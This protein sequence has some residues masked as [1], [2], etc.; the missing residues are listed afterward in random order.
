[1]WAAFTATD[2][3]F[4]AERSRPPHSDT[5]GTTAAVVVVEDCK[6]VVANVGD[7]RAIL[8][9][10][11]T[12]ADLTEDHKANRHDEIARIVNAGTAPPPPTHTLPPPPPL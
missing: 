6:V 1:L 7:S 3:A 2:A 8:C 4:E 9:R 10:D 11:G 12:A 5:S